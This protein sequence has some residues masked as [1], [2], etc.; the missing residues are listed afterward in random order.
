MAE[1]G[2]GSAAT[3]TVASNLPDGDAAGG[4]R[5]STRDETRKTDIFDYTE[6]REE[7]LR[8]A[9]T[10]KRISV[11]VLLDEVRNV[12]DDGTVTTEPRTAEEIRKLENLVKSAI[13]F[14]EE[15]GDLVT[16]ESISFAD[17]PQEGTVVTAS[18]APSFVETNMMSLIQMGVLGLVALILGLF[19][20]RPVLM[21]GRASDAAALSE[22]DAALSAIDVTPRSAE[23]IAAADAAAADVMGG[24][25]DGPTSGQPSAI[26]LLRDAVGSKND[27]SVDVIRGWLEDGPAM[28]QAR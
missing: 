6:T 9:G 10:I 16:V 24:A 4:E 2:E 26:D 20:V 15:R 17:V 27:E 11:A 3:T 8:P 21:A 25:L 7:V 22:E 5:S 23:D 14:D 13:G 18:T 1:A 28:E 19:V 12:A